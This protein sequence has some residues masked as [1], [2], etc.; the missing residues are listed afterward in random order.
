M[1]AYASATGFLSVPLLFEWHF[2]RTLFQRPL[3]SVRFKYVRRRSHEGS[4]IYCQEPALMINFTLK[5]LV[6]S[7]WFLVASS[8]L[9]VAG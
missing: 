4:G 2:R 9:L 7:C 8:K 1:E 5:L 6:P 3:P